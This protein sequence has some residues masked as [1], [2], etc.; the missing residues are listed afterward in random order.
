M[1]A[2]GYC[3]ES[4]W[5]NGKTAFSAPDFDESDLEQ[6][7]KIVRICVSKDSWAPV[8]AGLLIFGGSSQ[9]GTQG[10]G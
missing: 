8:D 2:C 1:I 7:A 10:T 4:T 9:Q 3:V 6:A 5:V